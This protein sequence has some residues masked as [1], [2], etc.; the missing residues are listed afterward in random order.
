MTTAP[1]IGFYLAIGLSFAISWWL[2]SSGID[3]LWKRISI[4]SMLIVGWLPVVV[5]ALLVNSVRPKRD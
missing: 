1:I 3:G 2:V 5:A 4:S